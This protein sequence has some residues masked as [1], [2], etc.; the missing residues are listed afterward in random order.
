MDLFSH[1]TNA[2]QRP[3]ETLDHH[4]ITRLRRKFQSAT[5]LDRRRIR[6]ELNA[7]MVACGEA[8]DNSTQVGT[9]LPRSVVSTLDRLADDYHTTTA[10][11]IR[12][13]VLWFLEHE[14]PKRRKQTPPEE[15]D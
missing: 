9:R 7:V 1:S 6:H 11:L 2:E 3:L 14:L 15:E 8:T 13:S 10:A 4:D 5:R 12:E